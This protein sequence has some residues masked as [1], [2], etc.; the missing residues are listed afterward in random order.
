MGPCLDTWG[1]GC[2]HAQVKGDRDVTAQSGTVR[3]PGDSDGTAQGQ[4]GLDPTLWGQERHRAGMWGHE[5]AVSPRSPSAPPDVED[6][7]PRVCPGVSWRVLAC[8]GASRV[9]APA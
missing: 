4:M 5:P 6:S 2:H 7:P 1:R 9:P 8:P 3:G